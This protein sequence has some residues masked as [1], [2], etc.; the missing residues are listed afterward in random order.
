METAR[1]F[2][3]FSPGEFFDTGPPVFNRIPVR[4]KFFN[5]F[6]NFQLGMEILQKKALIYAIL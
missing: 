5:F 3:L 6:I 2:N 1:R 4:G